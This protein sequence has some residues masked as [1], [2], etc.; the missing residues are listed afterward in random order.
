MTGTAGDM[1]FLDHLEELRTRIIWSLIALAI[2][3]GVGFWVVQHFQLVS[4]LKAPIA[5]YLPNGGKLTILNPTDAVMIVFKLSLVVGAVLASPVIF[6][7]IWAFFAPALYGREKRLIVPALFVGLGLF[8]LG[9]ALAWIFVIPKT[10][11]VLFSFQS[12]AIAPMITYEAYFGFIVQLVLA[13]GISFELPLIIVILAALGVVT[14]KWLSGF[15]RYAI[16]LA[17]VAG[18][19]LS[20]GADVLSMIMMT[21]PLLLLYEVGYAGAVVVHRRKRRRAAVEA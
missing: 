11:E 18:A 16:V 8:M 3:I 5:P 19:F 7:Q 20:P 2:G 9:G 10:L 13:L 4:I 14:P 1:P 15:R 21:I 6:W 12:E 17:C